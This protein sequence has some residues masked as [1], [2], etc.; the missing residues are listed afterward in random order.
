MGG[1]EEGEMKEKRD[2]VVGS[3]FQCCSRRSYRTSG[4]NP[5][6]FEAGVHSLRKSTRN[7]DGRRSEIGL[8]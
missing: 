7:H 6:V 1:K 8:S 2:R 4:L 3:R 5:R